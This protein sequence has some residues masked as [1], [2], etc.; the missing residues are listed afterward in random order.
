MMDAHTYR[1]LKYLA[2]DNE[3][4]E[5]V[6]SDPVR[7]LH[8]YRDRMDFVGAEIVGIISSWV[9]YGKRESFMKVISNFLK[10]K[11]DIKKYV[12][13]SDFSEYDNDAP[14]YR[15]FTNRDLKALLVRLR[16]ILTDFPNLATMLYYDISEK[17][18]TALQSLIDRFRGVKGFPTDTNSACKRLCL[19]LR[20]MVRQNSPV[21]LGLFFWYDAKDLIIPLDTHV[22]RIALELGLTKRKSADMKTALEITESLKEVFTNDPTKGDFALFGYGVTHKHININNAKE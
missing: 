12:M 6:V 4:F 9:A 20:W 10:D 14:F 5:F 16:E 1:H 21:D 3:T 8:L 15:F 22:H 19:F 7:F 18:K 17:G 13:E 2:E 11:R